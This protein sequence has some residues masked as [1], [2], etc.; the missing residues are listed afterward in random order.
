VTVDVRYADRGTTAVPERLIDAAR[1]A[2]RLSATEFV[3][4][5]DDFHAHRDY[6]WTIEVVRDGTIALNSRIVG[7]NVD[8]QRFRISYRDE[9]DL[10]RRINALIH[11]RLHR[12]RYVWP[13]RPERPTIVR[14]M[15]FSLPEG[16][17]VSV[18]RIQWL[19]AQRNHFQQDAEFEARVSHADFFKLEL[20]PNFVGESES[21]FGFDPMSNTS[22]RVI[23]IRPAEESGL[24]RVLT[25]A[26]VVL[27]L[28]AAAAAVPALRRS[29]LPDPAETPA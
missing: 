16:S 6:L 5:D 4:Y 29:R 19:D 17:P 27:L 23:L 11:D 7:S 9:E 3:N 28:A 24:F 2:V 25:I 12:V 13:Y 22:Y 15:G 1:Q 14:D 18:R 8:D 10:S 20:E 26:L 21:G